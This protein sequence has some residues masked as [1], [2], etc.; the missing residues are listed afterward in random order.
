MV[1]W[2]NGTFKRVQMKAAFNLSSVSTIDTANG[3]MVR[4]VLKTLTSLMKIVDSISEMVVGFPEMVDLSSP[5]NRHKKESPRTWQLFRSG[6]PQSLE[7][8]HVHCSVCKDRLFSLIFQI[9]PNNSTLFCRFFTERPFENRESAHEFM[10]T[11][12]RDPAVEDQENDQVSNQVVHQET[13]QEMHQVNRQKPRLTKEQQ[14]IVNF[15]SVPR[16][17]KEILDRKGLYNQSRARKKYILPLVE[18]GVLEM[19]IPENPN[20]KNQKYMKKRWSKLFLQIIMTSTLFRG[21]GFSR[22]EAAAF[23]HDLLNNV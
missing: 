21:A 12:K 11:I 14:D 18:M 22:Y 17:A 8:E 5:L 9:I 20:D 15:C 13:H 2:Y 3:T 23:M 10:I 4:Y 6:T 19:T 16:S 7:M 1:R